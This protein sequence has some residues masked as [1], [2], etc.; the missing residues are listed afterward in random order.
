MHMIDI[1]KVE[2][3]DGY[4]LNLEFSNGQWRTIDLSEYLRGE[5]FQSWKDLD[6]FKQVRVGYGTLVWPDDG[7]LAPETLYEKSQPFNRAAA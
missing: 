3:V 1:L 2:Y 7:D 5:A 4:R 6:F